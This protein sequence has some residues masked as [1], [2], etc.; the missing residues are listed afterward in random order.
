MD[1]ETDGILKAFLKERIGVFIAFSGAAGIVALILYL[2]DIPGEAMQYGFLLAFVWCMI[3]AVLD[4]LRYS[5]RHRILVDN[6]S[7]ILS[8]VEKLPAD[9]GLIAQDYQRMIREIYRQKAEMESGERISKQEMSDYY[10]MWVHQIKNPIAALKVLIQTCEEEEGKSATEDEARGR[11]T[12]YLKEMKQELFRIEQYADMVL[13]YLR[14][15]DMASDLSF[16]KYSLDK[17]VRQAVRKNS[18][19]FILR[20]IGLD[21]QPLNHMVLTDEKWMVFVVEQ[22]LTNALKYTKEGTVSI[23]MEGKNLVIADTGI[24]IWPEDLPRVFERGFTGYNGRADKK[25]TGIGLY[26]CKKIMDRLRQ[27]IWIKSEVGVGT[28]VYLCMERLKLPTFQ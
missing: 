15:E 16:E 20:K 22:I 7:K 26:L 14:M 27:E 25:S 21:Y 9:T 19:M 28:K 12:E 2:Y 8:D 10:V 13:T 6:F 11:R 23:Y 24:G 18:Q 4:F 17:I 3:F 1:R 5:H